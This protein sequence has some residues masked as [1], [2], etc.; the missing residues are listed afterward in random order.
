MVRI[1][2]YYEPTREYETTFAPCTL[3]HLH[4][5][6][7]NSLPSPPLP[8]SVPTGNVS[9]HYLSHMKGQNISA[10]SSRKV[11]AEGR[12]EWKFAYLP[13]PAITRSLRFTYSQVKKDK[14]NVWL[15]LFLELVRIV[16]WNSFLFSCLIFQQKY[17]DFDY[18]LLWEW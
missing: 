6:R 15:A 17:A 5:M 3:P 11:T 10:E 12:S 8:N 13:P 14:L 18:F 2:G 9:N 7:F 4:P 1:K 16:N